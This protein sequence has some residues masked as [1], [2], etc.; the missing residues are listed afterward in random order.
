MAKSKEEMT[1]EVLAEG[2]FTAAVRE[3]ISGYLVELGGP[4]KLGTILG[5]ISNSNDTSIQAQVALANVMLKLMG[6]A[7]EADDGGDALISD[8]DVDRFLEREKQACQQ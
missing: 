4:R 5:R 8:S 2:N 7:S 1:A 6:Q 3:V